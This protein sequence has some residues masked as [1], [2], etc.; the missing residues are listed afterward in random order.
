MAN[1]EQH[2]KR[3]SVFNKHGLSRLLTLKRTEL[4]GNLPFLFI[5]SLVFFVFFLSLYLLFHST[6]L[7]IISIVFVSFVSWKAGTKTG[8]ALL[9]FNFL[10]TSLSF[11]I[12][13]PNLGSILPIEGIISFAIQLG[14]AFLLGYFGKVASDLHKEIEVRKQTEALLKKYQTDLEGMVEKRTNELAK[15]NERLRQAEKMEAIGQMAGGV[16]HD[17][18]NYLSIIIGYS[19]FL[20]LTLDKGSKSLE[21][22]SQ[23]Q[24]AAQSASEL[25]SQLLTFSRKNKL[26]MESVDINQLIV[27]LIPLISRAMSK[28]ITINHMQK[29]QIP[30]FPGNVAQIQNALL[31]LALNARDAMDNSGVLTFSTETI[32]VTSEYCQKKGIACSLEKYVGVSVTDTGTGIPPEVF[33]HL[34]EPFYTTKEEGKGTGMGLAAVYGIAQSHNGAVF[35][36][37]EIGHGSTFTILFPITSK[38][39]GTSQA[40]TKRQ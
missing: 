28:N 8:I 7:A 37:T 18:N 11:H 20:V 1:S 32:Q 39:N 34:F 17:F 35:A 36:E 3:S 26:T 10:W 31:N 13:L 6:S 5:F 16:A 38:E 19:G 29:P 12:M 30:L 9:A 15:A 4:I 40:K 23:I 22:A 24:K 2:V 14:V 25:T 27:K 21:H 33:H